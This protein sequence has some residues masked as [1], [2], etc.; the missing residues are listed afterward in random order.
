MT[1]PLPRPPYDPATQLVLE[2]L[3]AVGAL[4]PLTSSTFSTLRSPAPEVRER[5]MARCPEAQLEEHAVRRPDG[6]EMV[7]T[8]GHPTSKDLT[9]E[10][11]GCGPLFLSLH[12]G[13][14]ILGCRYN[15]LAAP[16]AWAERFGGVVVSPEY[17]LAPEHPA[18]AASDDCLLALRWAVQHAEDLG[19]DP[20][21]VIVAG[22]SAGGGL[23]ASL[24]LASRD[25]SGP[26]LL[27][28]LLDYP[29]LDDR[30]GLPGADGVPAPSSARQYPHDGLWP[31][32]WN[33][34]AW[35]Q[36]LPGRRGGE[37]V[38]IYDVAGRAADI[39]GALADLP[40]LFLT[41]ASAETFRDEVVAFASALWRD[42]GDCELHVWPGGTHAMEQVNTTWL[43]EGLEHARLSWLER[44]LEPQDP[45]LNLERVRAA[46]T[47]AALS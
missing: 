38:G 32:N 35:E 30:T 20:G 24:A 3:D 23:G 1:S 14:R 45:Q 22:A 46:G 29:M 2:Q 33:N 7:L 28:C 4:L 25:Q 42:G 41:V 39:P 37:D 13:G 34:W 19:A 12:S 9:A 17:R 27:G 18:P 31:A 36:V 47:F 21:R 11:E 6:S 16:L 44:L 43:R 10:L 40:P 5:L 15:D 8:V 26:K